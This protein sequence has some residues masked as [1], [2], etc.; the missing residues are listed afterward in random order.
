MNEYLCDKAFC[1]KP[2]NA[3]SSQK[4]AR[5]KDATTAMSPG[6]EVLRFASSELDSSTA[7]LMPKI[8]V[9]TSETMMFRSSRATPDAS[10]IRIGWGLRFMPM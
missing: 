4:P 1:R 5:P 7:W 9:R 3:N 10:P 2:L 6:V 8:V